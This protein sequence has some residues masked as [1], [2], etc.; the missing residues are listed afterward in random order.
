[1]SVVDLEVAIPRDDVLHVLG[2]PPG[3]APSPGVER[4]LDPLLAEGRALVRPRGVWLHMRPERASSVGLASRRADA[5]VIGLVTIGG[6][7]EEAAATRLAQGEATASLVLEAC[8]SAAAEEAADAFGAAI[9]T[10]LAGRPAHQNAKSGHVGCRVSPGYA[11]WPITSQRP[12][13]SRLPSKAIGVRLEPSC[14]MVPRKSISFAM[15]V[16]SDP[17][18]AA[19]LASCPRC[20]LDGC[21]YRRAPREAR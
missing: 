17:E 8:G 4:L 11:R 13:F 3:Y 21:A 19:G 1:M 6:E 12:L 5:L 7:L 9:V 10:A 16:G 18:P 20:E 15:W 2:Y 14:L